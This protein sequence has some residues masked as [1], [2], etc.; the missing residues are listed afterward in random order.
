MTGF[1]DPLD[2][3]DAP[4][5]D[6]TGQLER[7]RD[8]VLRAHPD[9]VP[10]LVTGTTIADLL[11]SIEP[12]TTAYTNLASRIDAARPA[13]MQVPAGTVVPGAVDPDTLSPSEKVRRGLADL[14]A[15]H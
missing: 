15:A 12:A 1:I 2:T 4:S 9:V 8:L 3:N 13:P 11:A 14:R 10:E 6:D 5:T 7:I